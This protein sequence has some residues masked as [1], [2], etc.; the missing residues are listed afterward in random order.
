MLSKIVPSVVFICFIYSSAFALRINDEAPLFSLRD[1]NGTFFHLST[2]IG[3]KKKEQTRGVIVNFFSS[4]CKPCKKEL[5]VLN[6]LVDEFG[7]KG[8]KVVIIGYNEDFDR[9]ADMLYSLGVNK[10]IALSDPYGKIGEKYGV[11]S[12]PMTVFIRADG[13]VGDIMKGEVPNIGNV[14][15]EKAYR[16]FK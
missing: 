3:S 7:A 4:A 8:I 1:D 2:Y 13:K 11:Y 9:I 10:P 5:P 6:S 12:L 14:L 15:R 16:L